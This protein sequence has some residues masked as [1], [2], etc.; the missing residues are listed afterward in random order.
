MDEIDEPNVKLLYDVYHLWD[1]D[2]V[3]RAHRQARQ[4]DLPERPHLR[5]ARPD[6]ERLRPGSAGRRDHRPA[7]DLR[8][9]RGGRRDRVG[10]PRDL[11]GRRVVQRPWTST[12][13]CGSRIR[14]TSAGAARQG[15]RRP[16]RRGRRRPDAPRGK[17]RAR[18]R[19]LARARDRSR[20]RARSRRRGS[21]CRVLRHR[22]PRRGR[23]AGRRD[24]RDGPPI[25]V[26]RLRRVR[27]GLGRRA[28]RAGRAGSRPAR[29]RRLERGYG[30][31]GVV[32]GDHRR[33]LRPDRR[34][35]PDGRLQRRPGRGPGDG[36]I[37]QG[38][39]DRLH[40][41]RARAD[42]LPV[43]GD[44]RIDEAGASGDGGDDGDRAGA[45]RDHGQPHRARA[46]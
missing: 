23:A 14:S 22:L 31:L 24:P 42:G 1:T 44:L 33:E 15:S 43:D 10:R 34:R 5:L 26:L 13:R 11:L 18:H 36:A 29:H 45:V 27:S 46:G 28:D 3:R 8:G 39:T 2:D 7:G 9:A 25:D 20:D 17:G 21:R 19:R 30:R 40:V 6:P 12:T 16:G 37:G 32:H 41:V 35:Q 4:P 38:R